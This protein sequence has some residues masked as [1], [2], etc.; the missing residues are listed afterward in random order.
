MGYHVRVKV[1]GVTSV[2]DAVAIAELGA[3]ALG[4]NFYPPSPRC[5]NLT[6]AR[7]ILRELPPFVEPVG[8]FVEDSLSELSRRL[9]D[10]PGLRTV[11]WHGDR[12]EA[13][14]PPELER[15]VAF[16]VKDRDSLA[17]IS[18]FLDRCR[19]EGR[20]PRAILV[21]AHVPGLHGGTGKTLPWELLR[22]FRPGVP[23]VLAGG[24]TPENVAE[25]VRVVKPYAVDVASGVEA[26]PGRKDLDRVRRFLAAARHAALESP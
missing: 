11:Q 4:L 7:E 17:S 19:T 9:L 6:L 2:A 22:D 23:L 13:T 15:I 18:H 5:I 3:D 20:L 14:S 12:P 16:P 25:A 1:C 10:L 21:D 24:L 26:S 8:L